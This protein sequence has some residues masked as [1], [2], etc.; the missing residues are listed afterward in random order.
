M[1]GP[2]PYDRSLSQLSDLI[3]L[4][5]LWVTTLRW[6]WGWKKISSTLVC[7]V[8]SRSW[9]IRWFSNRNVFNYL[10]R[11]AHTLRQL[12]SDWPTNHKLKTNHSNFDKG[13]GISKWENLCHGRPWWS[14]IWFSSILSKTWKWPCWNSRV[15]IGW[16]RSIQK[17]IVSNWLILDFIPR[18]K[19]FSEIQV[20]S[21]Y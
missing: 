18:T 4:K 1:D 19:R 15:S 11:M 17:R 10:N 2:S 12:E 7:K 5:P 8:I 6:P 20:F 9:F 21:F 16:K 3:G 13:G 14:K